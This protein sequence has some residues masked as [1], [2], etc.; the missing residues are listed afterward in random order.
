MSRRRDDLTT[1]SDQSRR[2]R[3]TDQAGGTDDEDFHASAMQFN[4][5]RQSP[6]RRT[7]SVA[8]GSCN[9]RR[10]EDFHSGARPKYSRQYLAYVID[11]PSGSS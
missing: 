1:V 6:A 8:R 5:G 3:R 2:N 4:S 11:A 10:G 7:G 9:S